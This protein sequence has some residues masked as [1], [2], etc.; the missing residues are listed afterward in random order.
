VSRLIAR[1]AEDPDGAL[2]AISAAR[3]VTRERVWNWAGAPT[4]DRAVV[5]DLDATLLTAH[6]EKQDATRT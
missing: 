3:A 1:L 2:G 6:S 4:Q 5:L